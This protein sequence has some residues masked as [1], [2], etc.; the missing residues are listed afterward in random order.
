M[1]KYLNDRFV[2]CFRVEHYEEARD[3][4][5]K[6]LQYAR[7]E[8]AEDDPHT[9]TSLNNLAVA[10]RCLD[11]LDE[12]EK[13]VRQALDINIRL[14]GIHHPETGNY[15]NN[16]AIIHSDRGEF[17][18]AESLYRWAIEIREEALGKRHP[19]L[20]VNYHNMAR[21]YDACGEKEHSARCLR[22]M[23]ELDTDVHPV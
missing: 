18:E 16:L 17:H 13:L 5:E 1:W 19:D 9:A 22:H 23:R 15:L 4:A 6:A 20:I 11:Q 7:D 3:W 14:R 10:L 12:S 2:E 8:F 21:M